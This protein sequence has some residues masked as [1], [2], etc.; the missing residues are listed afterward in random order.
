MDRTLSSTP[1]CSFFL[2]GETARCAIV[3]S[4]LNSMYSWAVA[5]GL[6][7]WSGTCKEYDWEIGG[8]EV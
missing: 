8:K 3:H 5:S 1:G 6:T 7:G 2:E 4:E